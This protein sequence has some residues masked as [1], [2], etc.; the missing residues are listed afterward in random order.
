VDAIEKKLPARDKV[1]V[2]LDECTSMNK[3]AIMSVVANY[4][5]RNWA[6]QEVQF[7]FDVADSMVISDFER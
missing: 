1:S 5:N 2:A 6:W 3:L 7:G 4:M